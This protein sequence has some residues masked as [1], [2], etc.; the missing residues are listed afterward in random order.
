MSDTATPASASPES[1]PPSPPELGSWVAQCGPG[2][3]TDDGYI[4]FGTGILAV[5]VI[6]IVLG[7]LAPTIVPPQDPA[8][9]PAVI[10][11]F[12]GLGIAISLAGTVM[13]IATRAGKTLEIHAYEKGIA[14]RKK[15]QVR[16]ASWQEITEVKIQEFYESRNSPPSYNITVTVQEK[17]KIKF[18]SDMNGDSQEVIDQI[19]SNVENCRMIPFAG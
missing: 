13:L 17:P 19:T 1:A 16:T 11:L 12:V 9:G 6:V 14:S 2:S 10:A 8:D 5:G 15:E 18:C 3:R 4:M 7:F